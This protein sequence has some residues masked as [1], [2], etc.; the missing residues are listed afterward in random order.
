MMAKQ[1]ADRYRR[2]IEV[3]QALDQ[4][5]INLRQRAAQAADASENSAADFMFN[6]PEGTGN[7]SL[8]LVRPAAGRGRGKLIAIAAGLLTVILL[9]WWVSS[10]GGSQVAQPT[11]VANPAPFT[12]TLSNWK[13][14]TSVEPKK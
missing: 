8:L 5:L 10:R 4:V 1:P 6:I 11:T 7:S 9:G 14:P 13:P 3:A 12:S 2:P